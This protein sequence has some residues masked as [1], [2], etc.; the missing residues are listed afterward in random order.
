[1]KTTNIIAISVLS[2]LMLL[3][4]CGKDD[5]S[6]QNS[7][8]TE[9]SWK[10][11]SYSYS[12]RV[13]DQTSTTFTNGDPFTIIVI[14]SNIATANSPFVNCSFAI[15][16]NTST[17]GNYSIKSQNTAL[18]NT[19]LKNM[20][21]QCTIGSGVGTGAIYQS[22]DS[23]LTATV[24]QADGKYVITIPSG[25]TLTRTVNDGLA[26]APTTFVLTAEKVR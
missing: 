24:T 11:D 14:D 20:S 9:N 5:S 26:Q 13:S 2:V 10:L 25:V 7:V 8:T 16:F 15:T 6:P 4:C 17:V 3:T 19:K 1:M 21:I 18:T 12:R 22:V 23:S